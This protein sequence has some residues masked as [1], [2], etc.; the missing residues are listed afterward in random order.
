MKIVDMLKLDEP[1]SRVNMGSCWMVWDNDA[2]EWI[3]YQRKAYE[4][5]S[6]VLYRGTSESDACNVMIKEW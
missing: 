1:W 6:R 5:R 3:V 2:E 4:K